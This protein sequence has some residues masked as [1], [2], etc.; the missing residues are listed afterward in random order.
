MKDLIRMNQL[1]G[2][3]TEGQ[4]K[5]IMAILNEAED[6]GENDKI[7]PSFKSSSK[8]LPWNNI[9]QAFKKSGLT[10]E[11]F[12]AGAENEFREKFENKP[13]SRE[14]YYDFFTNLPSASGQDDRYTMVNWISFTNPK[15]ADELYGMI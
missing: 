12:F 3:I 15:L 2:I 6:G 11:E 5:K 7:T 4:A 1:A 9:E 14:A 13:V 10:G 8:S